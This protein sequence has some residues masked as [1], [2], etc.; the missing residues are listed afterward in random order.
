MASVGRL[1]RRDGELVAAQPRGEAI[2]EIGRAQPLRDLPQ[3]VVAR[4]MAE[5]VVDA[6]EAVEIHE[7]DRDRFAPRAGLREALV[8]R[9]VE[10]A[11]I[12]QLRE[13]VRAGEMEERRSM[14][15]RS[16]MSCTSP[17]IA[18]GRPA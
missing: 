8:E 14:R 13:I 1:Q 4:G 10:G 15:W 11:A 9:P 5:R 2:G 16:V 12:G 18:A 3:H 6:L 7:E 17:T